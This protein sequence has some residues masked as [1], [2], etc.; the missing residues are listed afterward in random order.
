MQTP[1]GNMQNELNEPSAVLTTREAAWHL[2]LAISTLNKWRVYGDGPVFVKLGR[3]VRY[4]RE[5]LEAFIAARS[6]TS[7]SQL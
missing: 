2:G 6:K 4:R 7:T 3:A 1:V 5:D